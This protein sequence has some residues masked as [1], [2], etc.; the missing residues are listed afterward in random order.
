MPELPDLEVFRGNLEKLFA[1]KK[2]VSIEASVTKKLNVS[3]PEFKKALEGKKL[4]SI[5]RSGKELF[6]NFEKKQVLSFHL[7][8]HGD[9]H[10]VEDSEEIKYKILE[11]KFSNKKK[12]ALSDF[13]KSAR[14]TLN[15]EQLKA[16]DAL[17]KEFT[18]KYLKEELKKRKSKK[19]KEVITDQNFIRGIGNAYADEI[20]WD[21]KIHPLSAAGAI[22]E[23]TVV[24]FFGAI[25][26][27][28]KGAAKKIKK[29]YPHIISGEKRE[30]MSVHS[31]HKKEAPDGSTIKKLS[32]GGRS[33]YYTEKQI[34]YK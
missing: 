4:I 13:Q 23:D 24:Y 28:L 33:T 9:F 31:S 18:L 15:P 30:F 17:S 32:L 7:M 11:M 26:K 14:V 29:S 25:R 12:L 6:F 3:V 8:L 22:P 5:N 16:P 27:V 20:L 34:Y 2:L 10:L 21:S 19:I 1:G